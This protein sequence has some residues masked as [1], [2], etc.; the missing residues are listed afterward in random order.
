MTTLFFDVPIFNTNTK[1]E[2]ID[3]VITLSSFIGAVF[4]YFFDSSI[5]SLAFF[6][7]L[8]VSFTV[9]QFIFQKFYQ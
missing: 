4:S 8:T 9:S 7:L 2:R 3:G 5:I 1:E 6:V